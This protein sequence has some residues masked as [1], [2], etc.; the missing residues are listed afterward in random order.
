M[1]TEVLDVVDTAVKIGLGALISGVATYYVTKLKDAEEVAQ[2]NRRRRLEFIANGLDAAEEYINAL[3]NLFS[4]LDGLRMDHPNA[5][6]IKETGESD[7][8][9]KHD[10]ALRDTILQRSRA[11][12]RLRLS[13]QTKAAE[14]LDKLHELE[15]EIRLR[16]IFQD[17]LPSTEAL[18]G[19]YDRIREARETLLGELSKTYQA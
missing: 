16:V 3:G 14:Q 18:K 11:Y 5:K 15:D 13:G 4:A 2:D 10:N 9:E 7:F 19:W 8:L 17:E 6:T 1:A 12:S